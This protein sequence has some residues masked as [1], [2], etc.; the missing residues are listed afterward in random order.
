MKR[1][2]GGSPIVV[3]REFLKAKKTETIN[4]RSTSLGSTGTEA[5]LQPGEWSVA[6]AID[7]AKTLWGIRPQ[8][9]SLGLPWRRILKARGR[10]SSSG[11][12]CLCAFVPAHPVPGR[13]TGSQGLRG[14]PSIEPHHAWSRHGLLAVRRETKCDK[15]AST[16]RK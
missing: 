13:K 12:K 10:N 6:D 1:P 4:T 15:A 5:G 9:L 3:E 8:Q 7:I 11:L 14:V 16:S 2:A